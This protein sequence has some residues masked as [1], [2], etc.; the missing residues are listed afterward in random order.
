M[1]TGSGFPVPDKGFDPVEHARNAILRVNQTQDHILYLWQS[2]YMEF[3]GLDS[4][5][6][7]RYTPE[8]LVESFTIQLMA[9]LTSTMAAI[10]YYLMALQLRCKYMNNNA[11]KGG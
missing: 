8:R 11:Q 10:G 5:G 3:Y 1:S 2:A 7:S 9:I 6:G 4:N